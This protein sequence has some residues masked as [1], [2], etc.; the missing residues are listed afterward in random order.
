[1]HPPSEPRRRDLRVALTDNRQSQPKYS[2]P[3]EDDKDAESSGGDDATTV[4]AAAAGSMPSA[5]LMTASCY[6][7]FIGRR[8]V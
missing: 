8:A 5:R 4:A 1:M 6:L 3:A 2:A 7:L